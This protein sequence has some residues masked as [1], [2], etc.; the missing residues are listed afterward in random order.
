MPRL[1]RS[2]LGDLN[3]VL[4][5]ARAGGFRRAA[6]DLDVSPS[7]LSH[8]VRGLEGRLGIRLFNRTSRSVTPTDAGRALLANLE[9]GFATIEDGLEALNR[10]RDRPAGRL[11]INALTDAARLLLGPALPGFIAAYPEVK[12]EIVVQDDFVDIVGEGFDAGIRFGGSV[13]EEMIATRI[14]GEMRWIMVAAPAYLADHPAPDHPDD[15]ARHRCIGMRMGTGGIY[16]WEIERG[17]EAIEVTADWSVIVNEAALAIQ[18]ARNGAGIAYCQE[19]L[20][21]AP[22]AAGDLRE[23]LPDWASLG[24][25][26]Q[27]YYPGRRQVP[28][29]LRAL[30]AHLQGWAAG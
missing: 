21:A 30:I 10:Y 22:L 20:A 18:L 28:H 6:L 24:P 9:T 11:R 27:V 17:T 14:G 16:H 8:A 23:V 26:F 2:D 29:A 4:A 5:I 3:L 19:L 15:L 25:A 13:P 7:A 12:L 1:T